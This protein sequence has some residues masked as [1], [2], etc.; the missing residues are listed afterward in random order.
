MIDSTIS[1]IVSLASISA[2]LMAGVYF[3]FSGFVMRSLD[4]LGAKPA[5]DAMNAINVVILR[6]WFMVLFFGSTLLFAMLGVM[7][8]FNAGIQGRWIL[9]AAGL[10]YIVGMFFCTMF[11]NVP[12]NN[13]L[14][15][16]GDDGNEPLKFWP[17]YFKQWTR[18]NHL[19]SVSSLI[20]LILC[21]LYLQSYA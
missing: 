13:Q 1:V 6:S 12:L 4:R 3:A 5:T 11:F 9:F 10:V 18:W 8:F 7:A 16:A 15:Q 21:L 14:A 17:I 20:A 2:G 19:R